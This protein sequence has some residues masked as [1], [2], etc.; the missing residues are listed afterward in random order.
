MRR[1]AQ[2]ATIGFAAL[3]V[4][5]AALA[6]GAPLGV[7]AWGGADAHLTTGQRIGSAVAVVFYLAAIVVLR[8][9]AAGRAARRYRWGAWALVAVLA[10]SA[11][12]NVASDSSWENS[13]LAPLALVLAALCLV[14][15]RSASTRAC[16]QLERCGPDATDV[17]PRNSKGARFTRVGGRLQRVP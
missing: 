12:M 13:L 11:A 15:A 14:V 8:R 1:A 9:R 10:T 7:A 2:A 16:P 5:Q 3:M 4:F 6:A 17:A